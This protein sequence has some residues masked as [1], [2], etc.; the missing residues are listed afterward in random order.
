SYVSHGVSKVDDDSGG[1]EKAGGENAEGDGAP[2]AKDPLK[3]Y[4]VNL[5]EEASQSRIDPLVGRE[6]EVARIVQILARRKKNNPLLVGDAG[7]G[8][9]AIAEGLA[10]KIVLGE[11]P[12]AIAR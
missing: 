9:T 7:V 11:V 1:T 3:A 6:N 10:R 5:N 4:T 12:K 8:K 2:P